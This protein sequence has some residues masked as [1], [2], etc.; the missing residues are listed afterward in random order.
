[1]S[2]KLLTASEEK[3]LV[4]KA[5]RGDKASR[6]RLVESN[7]G[8]VKTMAQSYLGGHLELD[9]LVM[10]GC[11]GL[12]RA[13]DKFDPA[14]GYRFMTYAG[15]WVRQALSRAVDNKSK[16]IRLP[17]YVYDQVRKINKAKA[18]YAQVYDEMPDISALATWLG[19][20][21]ESVQKILM[22]A[23][24]VLS[25]EE[26]V[27][28]TTL[29]ALIEDKAVVVLEDGF[30]PILNAAEEHI[31]RLRMSGDSQDTVHKLTGMSME[32]IRSIEETALHKLAD[33]A[34]CMAFV[35]SM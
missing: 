27:G 24:D 26:P 20:P 2:S 11:I 1:M 23:N 19:W 35:T 3:R 13:I 10:E 16:A 21:E 25:F 4:A 29:G 22:H 9:D 17:S 15:Q 8:F 32:R 31:L 5:Q 12:I 14:R 34:R 6:D 30:P 28:D 33:H 7:I 18:E